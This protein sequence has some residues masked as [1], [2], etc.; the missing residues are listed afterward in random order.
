MFFLLNFNGLWFTVV[1]TMSSKFSHKYFVILGWISF[2]FI[3]EK[4][5]EYFLI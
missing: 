4:S 3:L 5:I 2:F 1:K